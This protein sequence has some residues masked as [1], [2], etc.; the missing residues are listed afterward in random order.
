MKPTTLT[1]AAA[2]PAA[3]ARA[4]LRYEIASGA[5]GLALAIFMWGHMLLVGSILLGARGFDGLANWLEQVWIAQ[6][7]VVG[8]LVLF[9]VHAALASRKIPAQLRER[10]RMTELARGLQRSAG[11]EGSVFQPHLESMLWIWQV[12][13]GMVILVLGSFHV[14]L[15]GV[16]VLT[17]MFGERIGIEAATSTARVRGGLWP[18]YAVLLLAVEFHASVGLYR[19]FVKWG[20][21]ARLSRRTLHRLERVVFWVILG[22]GVLTLAV[23]AGVL[24]PPLAFLLDGA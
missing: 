15:V 8:V 1:P 20:V 9:L 3:D 21:G 2:R 11:R 22:L 24:E 18:V 23:L 4:Q 10:R 14:L 12:R 16:D 7:T 17:P 13:T 5:S 19:L 6:P